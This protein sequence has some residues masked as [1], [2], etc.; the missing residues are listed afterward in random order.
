MILA[1]RHVFDAFKDEY[2]VGHQTL[3]RLDRRRPL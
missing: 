2:Q 1:A 3:G